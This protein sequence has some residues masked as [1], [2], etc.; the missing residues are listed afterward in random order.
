M[1]NLSSK[2]FNGIVL[3]QMLESF[4]ISED[5]IHC[6]LKRLTNLSQPTNENDACTKIYVD[7]KIRTINSLY[8]LNVKRYYFY[9]SIRNNY[10][11]TFWIS[12]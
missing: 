1:V 12:G 10:K 11:P 8:T 3:I 4:F 6:G 2:I 9:L 5:E 7:S